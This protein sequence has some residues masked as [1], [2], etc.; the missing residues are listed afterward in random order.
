MKVSRKLSFTSA[1]VAMAAAAVL[2]T[3]P[4]AGGS[5]TPA[6][7]SPTPVFPSTAGGPPMVTCQSPTACEA[8]SGKRFATFN[9][10]TWSLGGAVP[11]GVFQSAFSPSFA[12]AT[13]SVCTVDSWLKVGGAW[14]DAG[15]SMNVAL[16]CVPNDP[17]HC[18]AVNNSDEV[19]TFSALNGVAK[20]RVH[21]PKGPWHWLG[22]QNTGLNLV[23]CVRVW[24]CT[25]EGGDARGQF[26]ATY[27]GQRWSY[28]RLP[29]IQYLSPIWL[30]CGA[31]GA[32]LMQDNDGNLWTFQGG[33]VKWIGPL[34]GA[35]MSSSNVASC[36]S[37]TSCAIEDNEIVP[38]GQAQ[39]ILSGAV[40]VRTTSPNRLLSWPFCT[41]SGSCF[42]VVAGGGIENLNLNPLPN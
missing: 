7:S 10:S 3:A 26:F 23:Q 16:S 18:M 12:C 13:P 25:A 32:C 29:S 9:G 11:A 38:P 28:V 39:F 8:I 41:T 35:T 24:Q 6:W 22:H 30:Q 27:N 42:A 36:A 1:L 40:I 5:T 14:A 4:V 20:L 37:A 33:Q 34:S 31:S 19:A 21:G 17:T 15:S 2:S